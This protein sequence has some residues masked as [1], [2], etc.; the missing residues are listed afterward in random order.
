MWPIEESMPVWRSAL[1]GDDPADRW[2]ARHRLAQYPGGDRCT[3]SYIVAHGVAATQA[4]IVHGF[5]VAFA[6]GAGLLL[7]G[8]IVSAVFISAGPSEVPA[9]DGAAP[10]A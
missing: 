8:A 10:S 4:G 7:L 1:V 6:V 3:A 9:A 5:A 2:I